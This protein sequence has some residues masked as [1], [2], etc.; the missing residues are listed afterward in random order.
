MSDPSAPKHAG[1]RR[2]TAA[3]AGSAAADTP[4]PMVS[5]ENP[6]RIWKV[7][8]IVEVWTQD[9][10]AEVYANEVHRKARLVSYRRQWLPGVIADVDGGIPAPDPIHLMGCLGVGLEGKK[11]RASEV[12]A[13]RV[14]RQK[15]RVK[16]R[17][18]KE[19]AVLVK[20]RE[21]ANDGVDVTSPEFALSRVYTVHYGYDFSPGDY[22]LRE[23]ELTHIGVKR[24]VGS[25]YLRTIKE[26]LALAKSAKEKVERAERISRRGAVVTLRNL[27]MMEEP[28]RVLLVVR[29]CVCVCVYE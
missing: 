1:R 17:V 27:L 28:A 21:H 15:E 3:I 16:E 5:L 8:D 9:P 29:V 11:G 6:P 7:G 12:R 4:P 25:M 10:E 2:A 19:N 23:P 24:R 14:E 20:A 13:A 18:K 26:G 22:R